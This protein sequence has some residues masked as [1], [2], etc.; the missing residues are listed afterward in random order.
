MHQ[1][2]QRCRD[3][4]SKSSTSHMRQA[5]AGGRTPAYVLRHMRSAI[6]RM[7][8]QGRIDH[9]AGRHPSSGAATRHHMQDIPRRLRRLFMKLKSMPKSRKG[10]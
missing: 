7:A 4:R 6:S 5:R 3:R 2:V 1:S 10:E 8:R 9:R